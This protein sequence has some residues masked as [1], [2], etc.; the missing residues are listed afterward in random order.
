MNAVGSSAD[1]D[2][3]TG[4]AVLETGGEAVAVTVDLAGRVEPVDGRYHWGGRVHPAPWVADLARR[5]D[6]RV[7]LSLSGRAGAPARLGG[8]DPWGGIRITGA[9]RPPWT[10]AAAPPSEP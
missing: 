7:T 4:P 3:Y 5:G 8:I 1:P 6:H 10:S 9:G 2:R